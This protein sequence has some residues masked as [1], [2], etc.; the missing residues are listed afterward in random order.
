MS[1]DGS[2]KD[3]KQEINR[4]LNS[5]EY[6]NFSP[7][8]EED[9][10]LTIKAMETLRKR[11]SPD[12]GLT[13]NQLASTINE[14][15]VYKVQR[16]IQLAKLVTLRYLLD[17]DPSKVNTF[18]ICK[19]YSEKAKDNVFFNGFKKQYAVEVLK[20]HGFHLPDNEK[21]VYLRTNKG[22][23]TIR[24]RRDKLKKYGIVFTK[25]N[26]E[27]EKHFSDYQHEDS[28][29]HDL[30][31]NYT[32]EEGLDEFFYLVDGVDN[33]LKN[34]PE[35]QDRTD[36]EMAHILLPETE[37]PLYSKKLDRYLM[38]WRKSQTFSHIFVHFAL[39]F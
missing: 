1:N 22:G 30:K 9:E 4:L 15:N 34:D 7:I 2:I 38:L 11:I 16:A 18:W 8:T 33:L 14:S 20:Y 25:Y 3:F 26:P 13:L 31:G 10:D 39:P 29:I 28:V 27:A 21:D 12:E 19:M 5:Q 32:T 24:V 36:I 17:I 37:A 6:N 35:Q 23:G